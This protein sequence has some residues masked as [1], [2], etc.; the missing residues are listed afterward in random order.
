M[1]F[2]IP[3]EAI[4]SD[5]ASALSCCTFFLG[6]H[7]GNHRDIREFLP[8]S[9]VQQLCSSHAAFAALKADG[10]LVA[11]GDEGYG[12]TLDAEVEKLRNLERSVEEC[13]SV[14]S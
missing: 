2:R 3:A 4:R 14:G 9:D 1:I 10:T 12:G 11:W 8:R 5:C 7:P 6:G 13:G